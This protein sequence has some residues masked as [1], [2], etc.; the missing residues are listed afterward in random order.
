MPAA[1]EKRVDQSL[2]SG[3][4]PEVGV[5]VF[6]PGWHGPLDASAVTAWLGDAVSRTG[7]RRMAGE[8]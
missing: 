7:L 3:I 2:R 5:N 1:S 6:E 4:D 8:A